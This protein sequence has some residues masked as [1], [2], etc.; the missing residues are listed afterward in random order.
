MKVAERIITIPMHM[1]ESDN[2]MISI[3]L[4][5]YNSFSRGPAGTTQQEIGASSVLGD[6]VRNM[7]SWE[8][9]AGEEQAKRTCGPATEQ[10]AAL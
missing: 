5:I 2:M 1:G 6:K 3:V 7:S 9:K 8:H 10:H 4:E